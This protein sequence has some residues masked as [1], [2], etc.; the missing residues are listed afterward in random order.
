MNLSKINYNY[1]VVHCKINVMLFNLV[2]NLVTLLLY[3]MLCALSVRCA[4]SWRYQN[5]W[6]VVCCYLC[7]L[8]LLTV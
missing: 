8:F 2:L 6:D 4:V 7:Q 1:F 5:A 3:K